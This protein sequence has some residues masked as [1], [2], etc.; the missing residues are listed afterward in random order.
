MHLG[1]TGLKTN[2][3]IKYL[4]KEWLICVSIFIVFSLVVALTQDFFDDCMNN[5]VEW[6]CSFNGT[7][8]VETLWENFKTFIGV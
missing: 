2:E 1:F 8:D 4:T 5:F 6:F 7:L 3:L